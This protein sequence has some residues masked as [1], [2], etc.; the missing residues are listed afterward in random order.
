MATFLFPVETK[1]LSPFVLLH[2][3]F[4][5]SMSGVVSVV[6]PIVGELMYDISSPPWLSL[7]GLRLADD[8]QSHKPDSEN[9]VR[10]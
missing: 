6:M 8:I 4:D 3:T 1:V 10:V 5:C 2:L 9:P 7:Q